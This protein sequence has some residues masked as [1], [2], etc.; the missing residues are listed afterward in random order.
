MHASKKGRINTK[1][2]EN[3]LLQRKEG[4]LPMPILQPK[5]LLAMKGWNM[6]HR[7]KDIHQSRVGQN[8]SKGRKPRDADKERVIDCVKMKQRLKQGVDNPN[9]PSTRTS[10]CTLVATNAFQSKRVFLMQWL[11]SYLNR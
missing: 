1:L 2:G 4:F 8:I 6:F 10:N 3:L 11:L 5:L 9:M 7:L